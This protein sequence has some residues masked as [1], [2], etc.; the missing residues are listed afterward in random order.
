MSPGQRGGGFLAGPRRAIG[1]NP[2]NSCR[3][4][5]QLGASRASFGKITFG[6][7]GQRFLDLAVAEAA[8]S[9]EGCNRFTL[10]V[11]DEEVA[12]VEAEVGL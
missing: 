7:I 3:V 9:I 4:G 5:D 11:A 8:P 10:G 1:E 6:R 2:L 12:E